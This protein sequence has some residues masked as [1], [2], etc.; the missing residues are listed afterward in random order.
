MLRRILLGCGIVASVLYVAT[1]VAAAIWYPDYHS[2]TSRVISE[3]M[4]SGAPTE[5]LVDPLFLIYGVLM[6]GFGVGMWMSDDR[7]RM[8]VAAALLLVYTAIGFL[9][10][11][12]F[13]M[14][15]CAV[16]GLHYGGMSS[17]IV[18]VRW[19]PPMTRMFNGSRRSCQRT[20]FGSG[21]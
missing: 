3:L 12:L 17:E 16:G 20:T 10:P 18:R 14:N 11:T 4:A 7:K 9:G 19:Q 1:D 2:F 13:E 8:H 21:A 15:G 6:L 5:R